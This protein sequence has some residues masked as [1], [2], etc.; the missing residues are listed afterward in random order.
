[1]HRYSRRGGVVQFGL[2]TSDAAPEW[3]QDDNSARVWERFGNEIE[4]VEDSHNRRASALLAKDLH[5]AAP[6][7]LSLRRSWERIAVPFARKLTERGLAVAVALHE[8]DASDG[9]KNPHFHFLIAMRQTGKEGFSRIKERWLD[10]RPGVPNPEIMA[11][12]REYFALVN[13]ALEGEGINGI[14]Y[15]PE[16]QE[17][18]EPGKHKGKT[19][20]AVE[21]K[22]VEQ[23]KRGRWAKVEDFLRPALTSLLETGETY[24]EG[25]GAG[26][27]ERRQAAAL[28]EEEPETS[29]A[30]SVAAPG[31]AA[32]VV[33]ASPVP[34]PASAP[35][36]SWQERAARSP[37][38]DRSR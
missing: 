36:S 23:A 13:A 6:R 21:R 5:A 32:V 12:R 29:P 26:W 10:S 35:A 15:D 18:I 33:V 8:T 2:F 37:P 31:P 1:M 30:P 11:L 34:V 4:A 28:W 16:K 38:A 27:W 14:T 19:A 20:W 17:G 7:E 22:A 3:T 25:L 9:G 24:Q